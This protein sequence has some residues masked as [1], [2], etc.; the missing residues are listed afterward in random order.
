MAI[1]TRTSPSVVQ[2]AVGRDPALGASATN[3]DRIFER[4]GALGEVQ[5][6]V[7]N[8]S[9]T[10]NLV[11]EL[12]VG[13]TN[14]DGGYA[15]R[16]IRVAGTLGNTITVAPL[17]TRTAIVDGPNAGVLSSSVDSQKYW[18]LRV[19]NQLRAWGTVSIVHATGELLPRSLFPG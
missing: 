5:I 15:T 17:Q 1:N 16:Q 12:Q 2:F 13:A 6:E 19:S 4:V 18:R 9:R 11:L 8:H 10:E 7:T 14:L 3:Q